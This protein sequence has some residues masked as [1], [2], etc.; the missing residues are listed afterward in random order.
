MESGLI[1][2]EAIERIS[3]LGDGEVEQIFSKAL[4]KAKIINGR[5]ERI[6]GD[7][8]REKRISELSRLISIISESR[9]RGTDLREKLRSEGEILWEKRKRQAEEQGKLADTK[10]ALPLGMMLVSLLLVTAAPALM[11]F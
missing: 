7:Y 4:R 11:Q 9:E 2:D 3:K 6:V 10:L 5:A 1:Y 8:A